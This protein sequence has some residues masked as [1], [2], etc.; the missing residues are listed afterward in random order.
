[1]SDQLLHCLARRKLYC[2]IARVSL[3]KTIAALRR[4]SKRMPTAGF[5]TFIL[6]GMLKNRSQMVLVEP[7]TQSFALLLS[8]ALLHDTHSRASMRIRAGSCN[9]LELF[10][11][12]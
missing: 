4:S 3:A 2:E 8:A 11:L 1:M 6:L 10:C 12:E 5:T 7:V 9:R